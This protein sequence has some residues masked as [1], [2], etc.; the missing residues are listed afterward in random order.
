[1]RSAAVAVALF[2]PALLGDGARAQGATGSSRTLVQAHA[3]NHDGVGDND[4]FLFASQRLDA[5]FGADRVRGGVRVDGDLFLDQPNAGYL[6]ELQLERVTLAYDVGELTFT[7]GDVAAQLGNGLALAVRS[8]DAVG[9]DL[10]VR[11][12]RV[13]WMGERLSAS[14]LVGLV[15]AANVDAVTLQHVDDPHDAVAGAELRLLASMGVGVRL[16]SSLVLPK[17]RVLPGLFDGSGTVGAGVELLDLAGA[18]R[19]SL[20]VDVQERVLAGVPQHGAAALG[21][22][23]LTVGEATLLLEGLT[24]GSFELKGS[25]N[26]ATGM[27]FSY[28]QPP[29][30][31]L[32]AQDQ[33]S[34][35]DL[36]ATRAR[37][38]LPVGDALLGRIEGTVR[39]ADP[40][41]A[42]PVAQAH[43]A[44]G[45]E[46][47]RG[48]NRFAAR[49]GARTERLGLDKLAELRDLAHLDGDVLVDLGRGFALH[50]LTALELWRAPERPYVVGATTVSLDVAGVASVGVQAGVDTNDPSPDV[51]HLFLA[52]LAS[53][54]LHE[55]LTLRLSSGSQRGGVACMGGVCRRIP[56]FA[57]TSAELAMSF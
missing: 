6:S 39:V 23:E 3:D 51:R 27:R 15:N 48:G 30:L 13:D 26:S 24:L 54:R 49:V 50:N 38:D 10:A 53:L 20:E 11:G 12:G 9:V 56:S 43:L 1:M 14:A 7:A 21:A 57:G 4:D 5:S 32:L 36:I 16:L 29:T 33:P 19:A 42:V 22:L 44:L 41:A 37:A 52:A 31:D 34:D 17:E 18:G 46:L 35:R 40:F 8:A 2:V 25:R 28:S 55:Q 47:A 45:L